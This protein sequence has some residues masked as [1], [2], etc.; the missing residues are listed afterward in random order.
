M[1][2]VCAFVFIGLSGP[3]LH[4]LIIGPKSL[5]RF[6]KLFSIAFAAYSVAWI[7]GWM[8]LR[9]DPGSI[10][11]LL[12][13]TAVMGWMFAHAFDAQRE[14][15]KVIAALF[16]LNAAGYFIGGWVE[17]SLIHLKELSIL[18]VALTKPARV[19]MAMLAW[20]VCYGIGF[21]AG[22]GI[23]FYLC[24]SQA[25]ALIRAKS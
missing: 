19:T 22:L 12:A 6:Y 23:A 15:L 3:L 11:G 4:R 13:G 24:Q 18:G 14:L 16:I 1:Y 5:S 20:G 21:G 2:A 25:R 8:S 9:G 17:G 7:V 10:A